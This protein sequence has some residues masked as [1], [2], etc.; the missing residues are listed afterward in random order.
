MSNVLQAPVYSRR[1]LQ[2]VLYALLEHYI[3]TGLVWH[4]TAASSYVVLMF[5][6]LSG[7]CVLRVPG[8]PLQVPVPR[9]SGA[10]AGPGPPLNP[11]LRGVPGE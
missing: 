6:L 5:E 1:L 2:V 11:A 8:L 3:S 4:I 7:P 9:L 10:P